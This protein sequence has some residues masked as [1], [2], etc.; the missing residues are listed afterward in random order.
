MTIRKGGALVIRDKS[1]ALFN[2]SGQVEIEYL[3]ILFLVVLLIYH[4]VIKPLDRI[5]VEYYYA[6]IS[7]FLSIPF[8]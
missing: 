2:D 1:V 5:L 3:L 6:N 4:W 7:F 8:P